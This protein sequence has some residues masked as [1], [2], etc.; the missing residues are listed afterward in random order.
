MLADILISQNRNICAVISPDDV[1]ARPAFD[2]IPILATDKEISRFPPE[3][4]RLVNGI[5]MLPF[6]FLRCEVNEWYQSM[7]YRFETVVAES[8][9]VSKF[10][11]LGEGVQVFPGAIIQAG[12]VVGDGCIINTGALVEHDCQLGAF[13]HLAPRATLCGGVKTGAKVFIGANSTV[14]QGLTLSD[15][16]VVG[17]GA[18]LSENLPVKR[19]CYPPRSIIQSNTEE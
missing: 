8:A 1:S 19:V 13:N 14:I 15:Q 16:S 2:S 17:A 10:A 4:V 7:G 12:V 5:G 11:V 9:Q 18:T 3:S 6:T